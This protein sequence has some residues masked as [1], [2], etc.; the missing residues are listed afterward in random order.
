MTGGVSDPEFA[1]LLGMSVEQ[2]RAALQS[3]ELR[4]RVIRQDGQY[5]VVTADYRTDRVNVCVV[6][7]EIYHVVGLG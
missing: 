6:R 7:D 4:L 5:G 2:G 3:R 1:F